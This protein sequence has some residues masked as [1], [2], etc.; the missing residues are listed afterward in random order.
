MGGISESDLLTGIAEKLSLNLG[1]NHFEW[2]GKTYGDADDGLFVA[3]PNPYNHDKFI[4]LMIANSALQLH[5]M[6]KDYH[7]NV[8]AWALFEKDQ[9]VENGHHP[10]VSYTA[11][12]E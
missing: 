10:M 4:F 3:Y 7:R 12:F 11:E 1:V 2:M 5:M 6:T 8:P 9:I